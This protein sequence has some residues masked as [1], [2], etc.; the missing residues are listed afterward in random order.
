MSESKSILIPGKPNAKQSE[1]FASHAR[2][3][4]YG[5]ARGGGKSWALRRKLV[6][7]CLRNEG[8]KCLLVRRS[9]AEVKANHLAA[10]L[11]EYGS[12][13]KYS[14]GE[15]CIYFPNGSSISFGYCSSDRDTLRYQGQEYDVIAIDEATQLSEHQFSIFKAWQEISPLILCPVFLATRPV[16]ASVS[17]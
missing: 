3:V 1:F 10:F 6:A 7:I 15:K 14:E 12:F 13:I 11:G 2:F 5:G 4:A 17:Q 9:Y 16:S 8:A